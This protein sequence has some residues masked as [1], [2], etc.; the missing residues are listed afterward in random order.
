MILVEFRALDTLGEL[1]VL[2]MAGVAIVAVLSSVKDRYLEPEHED[3]LPEP[4]LRAGGTTA[5]RAIREAWPNL[6]PLQLV[7]RVTGPLL[8]LIS[9]VL[10]M[11]GH[12]A[13]GGGFIAAL[14]ASAAIGLIYLSTSRDRRIG[15]ARLPLHLIGG[16]VAFAI[17]TG[18]V[19]LVVA[20]S[21]LEPI[22][23]YVFTEHVSTSMLFDLGVF[24]AVVGLITVAF[25]LLG[26][27]PR[28]APGESTGLRVDEAV[29]GA[30]FSR[31]ESVTRERQPRVNASTT[32]ILDGAPPRELGR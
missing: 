21:F 29:E 6:V 2:G 11:R 4:R 20:D 12:N 26:S 10:F 3:D 18:I 30:L 1:T 25:N 13:P 22:Y 15:P 28:P 16:G 32:H 27:T 17:L 9:F 14:V 19:G 5:E 31:P 24:A 7:L 8:L 23:G